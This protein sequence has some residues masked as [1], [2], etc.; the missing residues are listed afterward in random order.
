MA[1]LGRPLQ[2][3]AAI[4]GIGQTDAGGGEDFAAEP[5]GG[6]GLIIIIFSH[7]GRIRQAFPGPP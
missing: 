2:D 3:A 5:D 6:A 4:V 1:R 7:E